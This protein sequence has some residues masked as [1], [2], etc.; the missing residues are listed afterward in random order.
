VGVDEHQ[1]DRASYW[2]GHLERAAAS[3][4]SLRQYAEQTGVKLHRLYFW[5]SRRKAMAEA[6]G[7]GA[8]LFARVEVSEPAGHWPATRRLHL[9]SG[10]VLEWE[11]AA[12]LALI[13][14]LL[15]R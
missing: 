1:S 6:R 2:Y 9:P 3:G 14:H 12:D 11:G 4:R 7:G 8:G 5:S 13:G 15:G 10:A